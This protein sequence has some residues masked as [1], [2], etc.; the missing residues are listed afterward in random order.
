MF[1]LIEIPR[2]LKDPSLRFIKVRAREK[3]GIEKNWQNKNH[4]TYYSP[5]I[6][7]HI[8]K[9]GNY[10]VLCGIADL[11]VIDCDIVPGMNKAPLSE[12]I[13][14]NPNLPRTLEVMTGGGGV[15]L[16]YFCP[17]FTEKVILEKDGVHYGEV[18]GKGAYVVA[19]NSIH[20]SGKFYEIT[21]SAPIS[22]IT[23]K[24]LFSGIG[25]YTKEKF[26][27]TVIKKKTCEDCFVINAILHLAYLVT[28]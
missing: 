24:Q 7:N 28:I 23:K 5:K 6:N 16:Y 2:E 13:W 18:Q 8:E 15:H 12:E 21:N 26:S 4:Y 25:K 20:A 27:T 11:I 10:G 1:R 19:P 3:R 14:K 9:N 17:E 22:T